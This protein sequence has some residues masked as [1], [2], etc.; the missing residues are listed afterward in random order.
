[1]SGRPANGSPVAGTR[2]R[3]VLVAAVVCLTFLGVFGLPWIVP[4]S[5]A[6]QS[7]SLAVG[8]SNLSAMVALGACAVAIFATA[9]LTSNQGGGRLR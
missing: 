5:D 6:V 8:F 3:A 7:E 2:R 9:Q 1:M 4:T